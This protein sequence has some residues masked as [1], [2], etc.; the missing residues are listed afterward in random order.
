MLMHRRGRGQTRGDRQEYARLFGIVSFS[1]ECQPSPKYFAPGANAIASMNTWRRWRKRPG[2]ETD[3]AELLVSTQRA[4]EEKAAL[5]QELRAAEQER[6]EAER[7]RLLAEAERKAQEAE[8]RAET[9]RREEQERQQISLEWVARE[10][11]TWRAIAEQIS[12]EEEEAAK[13]HNVRLNFL[14]SERSRLKATSSRPAESSELSYRV[15]SRR[16]HTVMVAGVRSGPLAKLLPSAQRLPHPGQQDGTPTEG[17]RA[18]AARELAWL[19]ARSDLDGPT[20]WW[21]LLLRESFDELCLRKVVQT[22][23]TRAPACPCYP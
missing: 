8:I 9:E 4:R 23:P 14:E 15:L 2:E 11:P 19:E 7:D 3:R 12:R 1:Y 10:A 22:D 13:P 5:E 16:Q 18:L 21:H 20:I 6:R 17:S